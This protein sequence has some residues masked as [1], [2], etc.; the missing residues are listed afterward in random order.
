MSTILIIASDFSE[1]FHFG[2]VL[3]LSNSICFHR[4]HGPHQLAVKN[5]IC[6]IFGL[7]TRGGGS[8]EDT[9]ESTESCWFA[10]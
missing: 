1:I 7:F 8:S 2:L 9:P 4:W 3:N 5:N 6:F 10:N